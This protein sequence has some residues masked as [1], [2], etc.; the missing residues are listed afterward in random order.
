MHVLVLKLVT[1]V[2][3]YRLSKL[4]TNHDGDKLDYVPSSAAVL[5]TIVLLY[6][7]L[8]MSLS[9]VSNSDTRAVNL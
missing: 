4:T 1:P 2:R 3:S 8:S 5:L 9:T 7:P 6:T